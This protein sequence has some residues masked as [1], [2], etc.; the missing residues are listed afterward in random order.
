VRAQLFQK[1]VGDPLDPYGP[2]ESSEFDRVG[3]LGF[4]FDVF[5]V[6]LLTI[7]LIIGSDFLWFYGL[8]DNFHWF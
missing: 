7:S 4:V 5:C 2:S 1:N 3:G 8:Y 6:T